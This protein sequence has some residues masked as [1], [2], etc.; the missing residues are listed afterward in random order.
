MLS[1]TVKVLWSVVLLQLYVHR[2]DAGVVSIAA[3]FGTESTDVKSVIQDG[4]QY[5]NRNTSILSEVHSIEYTG[6]VGVKTSN[7][8]FSALDDVCNLISGERPSAMILPEDKCPDCEDIAGIAS[9]ASNPVFSLDHGSYDSGS[10][11]FKMHPSPEDT[12]NLFVDILEYFEW[13]NFIIVHD[14]GNAL[15][16]LQEVLNIQR[17]NE[18]NITAIELGERGNHE[19]YMELAGKIKAESS[20]NLFLF[21]S[22]EANA[23]AFIVWAQ[24]NPSAQ[25]LNAK[26][27][28]VLGNIDISLDRTFRTELEKTNAY[29]TRFGMNYTR[30]IQ[31]AQPT[32]IS[33]S[34]TE[35][36]MRNR[37]AFDAVIAVGHALRLYREWREDNGES[38]TAVL[39]G[40]TQMPPCPT[41]SATPTENALSR[42]LKQVA[43]EGIS[44][45]VE[46]DSKGNRVNYTISIYSGQFRTLDQ[47]R[48]EW[49][50]NKAYW[51]QKWKRKWESE[52]HLNVTYHNYASE[53][54]IKIVTIESKPFLMLKG[55]DTLTD[56]GSY[57]GNNRFEGY[58]I[59][60]MERIK[61]HIKGIDFDYQVELVADGKFG[62]S[63]PYSK[64]WDG[65]VGDVV[66]KKADIA[67]G[68][69]T[70]TPDRAAAIDFTYP[71]MS[72]GITILMKHPNYVQ[73]NPFRIMYP[74]GIEVWFI[75]LVAF[76][77]ISA[78]LYFFNYFDPYEWRAAAERRETFEENAEN[79]TMK[80]SLWFATTTMFLQSFDAS[81]RS[82]AG[83][84]LAAFWWVFTIIM[85]FLYLLNLT[86]FVTTN[87]RLAYAK[88]AEDLLDQTEVA[89]GSVEKGSTYFYFKKSSVPE[90][91]RL[92]QHM[93]TRIPSPWVKNVPE[94]IQRVR[95]SN[96][97]YAF[98]G[99][100]GELNFLASKRPCD[101]LVSGTY[102]TRTTYALAVQKGSPLRDQLSSAIE[103]LRDTGVLEDLEREWWDLDIRH[104]ECANLTTWERQGVFSLTTV[105][106]Q[107]VYYIL[108]IGII[109]AAVTFILESI[110][111]SCSGGKKKSSSSARNGGMGGGMSG[112][113]GG[114]GGAVGGPASGGGD[115]KM[116]I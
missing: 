86:H 7:S 27:H 6:I 21:C 38:G 13:R 65:M 39:P 98:I 42:Y 23:K 20:R 85:V 95:D 37:L 31:Y 11:A 64:I 54:T 3:L 97:Y 28:W 107:G 76:F 25:I 91:Q 56:Q 63:H 73:H 32:S 18:W 61:T 70:V 2:G 113:R 48:G 49:T 43:F 14:G 15:E 69:L 19:G 45:N 110:S 41:S 108:V 17:V 33:T 84:C 77:I 67:A 30:E 80:N 4:V 44:G 36:P 26:Y 60:L 1:Q 89:F 5:I 9:H 112:P 52:G 94:G 59:D 93:N 116:W 114:G 83:R 35:W 66:R 90:F 46:F 92:W 71:F 29:I 68:P 57:A 58:I 82:N 101:L 100:A 10:L 55:N 109:L 87:K 72:S 102:I 75:N 74:F 81:P 79:F 12:N 8:V 106:L 16:F 99:E 51:E 104:Q 96:G 105:D 115:E 34:T 88:T 62:S 50:Q 40:D 47:M 24:A 78:M 103:S 22:S 111:Y 53:R